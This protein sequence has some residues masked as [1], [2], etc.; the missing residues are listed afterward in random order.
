MLLNQGKAWIY[1]SGFI[2][3]L[4]GASIHF[5]GAWPWM[6]QRNPIELHVWMEMDA[7][8]R[9]NWIC[10]V[11]RRQNSLSS[12]EEQDLDVSLRD[13]SSR[14][15]CL[16]LSVESACMGTCQREETASSQMWL[17]EHPLLIPT[18]DNVIH[19][20]SMEHQLLSI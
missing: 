10:T 6:Q 4:L 13:F 17:M 18:Q 19:L 15:T 1:L 16:Y 7:C 2:F 8:F 12:P 5:V 11:F 9:A 3:L 20:W 14:H